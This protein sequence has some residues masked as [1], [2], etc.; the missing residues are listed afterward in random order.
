MTKEE[1][2]RFRKTA[3]KTSNFNAFGEITDLFG[4]TI[5]PDDSEEE[6]EIAKQLYKQ[7]EDYKLGSFIKEKPLLEFSIGN[8]SYTIYDKHTAQRITTN[9]RNPRNWNKEYLSNLVAEITRNP[10]YAK[11]L[12]HRSLKKEASII[13]RETKNIIEHI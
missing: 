4:K 1:Q 8:I 6:K 13:Y 11:L 5:L 10:N 2:L 9:L 3:I 7:Y 12:G